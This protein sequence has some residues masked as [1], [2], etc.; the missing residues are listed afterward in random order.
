M[1]LWRR[2]TDFVQSTGAHP[3]A[4]P[5]TDARPAEVGKDVA[6]TIA[7]I[8][9]G[10]KLAKADGRVTGD[11]VAA[12]QR[13]FRVPPGAE[14]EAAR[15][16]ARAQTTTLGFEGYARQLARRWRAYP[17]L[18]E[19]VLD[20]LF[21]VAAADGVISPDEREYLARVAE[22][23]G[24]TAPEIAR[25][26]ASWGIAGA[27]DDYAVLGV[28]ASASDEDVRRAYRRMAKA[29]HPDLFAA[30]GL[31]GEA[32]RVATQKMAAVNAAYRRV[33]TQRGMRV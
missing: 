5:A 26:E 1:G 10:A 19:D 24:F 7:V 21:Y 20:G 17:C 3:V 22:I 33:A 4:E 31:P 18:L 30:R 27:A 29:N 14:A 15:A 2:I 9:L 16:F 13:V 28:D 23:F 32:E 25:L 11:E 6:F 12:F 8:G